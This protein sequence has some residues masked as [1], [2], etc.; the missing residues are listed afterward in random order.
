VPTLDGW[1]IRFRASCKRE[2]GQTMAE[3]GVVLAVIT[4]ASV[5]IFSVFSGGVEGAI[6]RVIGFFPG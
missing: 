4:A 2:H 6:N 3:Y 5:S 1:L